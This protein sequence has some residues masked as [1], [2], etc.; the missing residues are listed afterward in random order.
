MSSTPDLVVGI[1]LGTTNSAIA[2]VLN[3]Q[4]EVIP[5]GGQ[6]TMPSAVGLDPSGQLIIGQ[7]ARNQAVASPESTVLS[8]KRLMGTDETVTLGDRTFRPEEISALILGELKRAAE[9]HLGRAVTHAVITVPAFFNERQRQA[10]QDA[11]R[12]AGLE[13]LRIINE[14]TAAALAYGADRTDASEAELL[15]VYDLGGGTFDVSLVAVDNGI[16]EVRASHGDTHLGGDDF[17]EELVKLASTSLGETDP[18]GRNLPA[19]LHRR[20]KVVM[21]QTKI[22]L[23]TQPFARV[24]EE[25]VTE[26]QHL[27]LEIDRA[28]YEEVIAPL[29]EKT[30]HAVQRALSDAEMQISQLQKVIL[31]GGA[32]RTPAV[33]ALLRE[34]LGQEPHH[35]V[36]PDLI[37]AMGAA[38]QGAALA[39]QP[40]PAILVDITAHTYSTEALVGFNQLECVPIIRRGTALPAKRTEAFSTVHDGQKEVDFRVFQGESPRPDDNLLI[41]QFMVEG[42]S[43][44]PAGNLV[45]AT[46]EIDLNGLLTVTSTEKATG[47]AKSIKIDT[48]EKDRLDLDAAREKLAGWLESSDRALED[49]E[50]GDDTPLSLPEGGTSA[51][52]REQLATA[53]NLRQRA[54]TLLEGDLPDED[55][56]AVRAALE[57]LTEA[58]GDTDPSL[59]EQAND[60][61]SDLLFYLEE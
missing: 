12:L 15:L 41:G 20:L 49:E 36:D 52:H 26:K 9:T 32:T 19:L 55:A 24:R 23:S 16:V 45:L 10:T 39:G 38:I 51:S 56:E 29:L 47:L 18:D 3:H 21:E 37:V 59:I 8:V 2:A 28:E 4:V 27:D 1:D 5:V 60:A 17:D 40:A 48:G 46:Y 50:T 54:K 31:V 43:D 30:L 13:V 61:L 14:P 57:K 6:R 22:Q 7:P 44:V 34:Q 35:E 25:F 42:L 58:V 53:K 33:H 11:G